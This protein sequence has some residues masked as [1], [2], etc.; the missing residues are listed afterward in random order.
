VP[1]AWVLSESRIESLLRAVTRAHLFGIVNANFPLSRPSL[2]PPPP[3][4]RRPTLLLIAKRFTLISCAVAPDGARS[5]ALLACS[6]GGFRFRRVL[7]HSGCSHSRT[8]TYARVHSHMQVLTCP[9]V[10]SVRCAALAPSCSPFVPLTP[11]CALD[12]RRRTA[13][14]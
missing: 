4:R 9:N 2:P 6:P 10:R 11:H 3:P 5:A 14:S 7:K 13:L 1:H 8:H 12:A